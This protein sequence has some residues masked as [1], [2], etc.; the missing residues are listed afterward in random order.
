VDVGILGAH[1]RNPM[2]YMRSFSKPE[3]VLLGSTG[4]RY[5]KNGLLRRDDF[6]RET[7]ILREPG[8]ETRSLIETALIR[9]GWQPARRIEVS[10][11]EGIAAAAEQGLG[12]APISLSE[13]DRRPGIRVLRFAE[14]QI[15]GEMFIACMN[16]RQHIP[17]IRSLI[18]T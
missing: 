7:L 4:K 8:S 2:L 9:H 16:N 10:S 13:V 17:S 18:D 1:E 5:G 3:I 14:F 12:L 6:A 11:R 15:H